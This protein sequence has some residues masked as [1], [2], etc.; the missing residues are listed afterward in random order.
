MCVF[1]DCDL[2]KR[3]M[4]IAHSTQKLTTTTLSAVHSFVR[5]EVQR[6]VN[7]DIR[8]QYDFIAANK[9]KEQQNGFIFIFK[10]KKPFS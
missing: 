9:Q 3:L 8:F 6:N 10:I 7:N 1:K 2:D 4:H 5:N